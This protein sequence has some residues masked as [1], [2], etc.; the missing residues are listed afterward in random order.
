MNGTIGQKQV[1]VLEE[2]DMSKKKMLLDFKKMK[3]VKIKPLNKIPIK[4]LKIT[5]GGRKMKL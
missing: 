4:D 1:V 5:T 3:N 2:L